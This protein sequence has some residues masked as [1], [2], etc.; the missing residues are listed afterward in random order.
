MES[1]LGLLHESVYIPI[2]S[3]RDQGAQ[4]AQALSVLIPLIPW[5]KVPRSLGT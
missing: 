5:L 2:D 1:P 4:D 3:W